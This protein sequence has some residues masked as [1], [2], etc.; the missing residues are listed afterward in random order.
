MLL[1]IQPIR[2]SFIA[3]S[4]FSRINPNISP[5]FCYLKP[6]DL[7]QAGEQRDEGC[8]DEHHTTTG[9]QLLD[10]LR[11]GARVVGT[12]ALQQID[13]APHAQ[14][15]AMLQALTCLPFGVGDQIS[16]IVLLLQGNTA[17]AG[18][19]QLYLDTVSQGIGALR[20]GTSAVREGYD[21]FD[22]GIQAMAGVL[23]GMLQNMALLSDAVTTLA[24]QYGVFDTGVNAYTQGVDQ[25]LA[26]TQQLSSASLLLVAGAHQLYTETSNMQLD[27][28]L[29]SLLDTLSAPGVPASFTSDKNTVSALQFAL[30]TE[31][32]QLDAA[33]EEEAA[34]AHE[35]TFWEKLLDLFGLYDKS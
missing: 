32:I 18:A 3:S 26:G 29:G 6:R 31:P 14:A 33:A 13:N 16:Q 19:M 1:S 30:Q 10:A 5:P 15:I 7:E 24:T 17:L 20:Q 9:H 12:V 27:E 22:S 11:F 21:A 35:L 34:P 23:N 25:I 4:I 28:E 2:S 8:A